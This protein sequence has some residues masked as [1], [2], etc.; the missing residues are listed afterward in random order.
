MVK[1]LRSQK[2]ALEGRVLA[3]TRG[4]LWL[5]PALLACVASTVIFFAA[6]RDSAS[7]STPQELERT[8]DALTRIEFSCPSGSVEQVERWGTIGW[9][10]FCSRAGLEHGPWQAWEHQQLVISGGF[11]EGRRDG[12]WKIFNRDGSL[13]KSLQYKMGSLQSEEMVSPPD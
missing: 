13:H 11:Y 12:A 2:L 7:L 5:S 4:Y 10:R 6:C 3:V 1:S 9:A 8:R